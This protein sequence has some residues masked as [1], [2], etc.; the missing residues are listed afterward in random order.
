MRIVIFSGLSAFLAVG[1]DLL[2]PQSGEPGGSTAGSETGELSATS[3]TLP[4]GADVEPPSSEEGTIGATS[5]EPPSTTSVGGSSSGDPIDESTSGDP[6]LDLPPEPPTPAN[7]VPC[8]WLL[9]PVG[10]GPTPLWCTQLVPEGYDEAGANRVAV[11]AEGEIYV[12]GHASVGFIAQDSRAAIV[13]RYT[14]EGERVWTQ[15]FEHGTLPWDSAYGVA[16]VPGGDVVVAG[17]AAH[18]PIEEH[19]WLARLTPDAVPLWDLD[20]PEV[21]YPRRIEAHVDGT[22]VVSGGEPYFGLEEPPAHITKHAPDGT[23]AWLYAPSGT[24]MNSEN[25]GRSVAIDAAGNVYVSGSLSDRSR[26]VAKLAPDGTVLWEHVGAPIDPYDWNY[27]EDLVVTPAG[28][29]FTS[30]RVEDEAWMARLTTDGVEVWSD[31][32][33]F[34]GLEGGFGPLARLPDGDLVAAGELMDAEYDRTLWLRRYTPDGAVVWD[35]LLPDPTV[36]GIYLDDLAVTPEGD[37]V[38]VGTYPAYI[39]SFQFTARLQP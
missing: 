28:D 8:N 27:A 3:T 33:S 32:A 24:L 7:E 29:V 35:Y 6:L 34:P 20:Q 5:I 1:C 13:S 38:L 30:G 9:A 22:F 15:A 14:P 19:G 4:P 25:T 37:V 16:V 2:P 10:P 26:F 31:F 21:G 12:T 36:V 23:Q 39:T 11:G 17:V 18:G